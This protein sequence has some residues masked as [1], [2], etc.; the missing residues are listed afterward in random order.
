METSSLKF[1]I[2][3]FWSLDEPWAVG[4]QFSGEA[5]DRLE[6]APKHKITMCHW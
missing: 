5:Q 2:S 6:M 1:G 4:P 3:G